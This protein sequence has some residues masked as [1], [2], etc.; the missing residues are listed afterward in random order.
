MKVTVCGATVAEIEPGDD[1]CGCTAI[2]TRLAA[3]SFR[4]DA[5]DD[6]RA[7][8]GP[9]YRDAAMQR[10]MIQR[11]RGSHV[12]TPPCDQRDQT[13][14]IAGEFEIRFQIEEN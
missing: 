3:P 4:G 10:K 2:A 13:R 1:P 8:R 11:H 5:A 6:T 14:A 7:V 12:R 9:L